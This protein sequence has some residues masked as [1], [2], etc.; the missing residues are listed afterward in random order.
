MVKIIR[1]A[2]ESLYIGR[3][4]ITEHKQLFDPQTKQT[5]FT[6]IDIFIDVPCRLSFSTLKTASDETISSVNQTTKLFLS[7]DIEIPA[8]CKITVTQNNR[9]TAYKQ[10]SPPAVHTN[11]QEIQLELFQKWA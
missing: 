6:D 8:G 1:D 10:S 4:T 3:C 5:K 7:P 2:I 9:T 11:H